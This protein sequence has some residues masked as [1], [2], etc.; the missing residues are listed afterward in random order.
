MPELVLRPVVVDGEADVVFAD[1]FFNS[2][3]SFRRRVS[4]NDDGNP[5]ALAVFEFAADVRVVIFVEIDGSGGVGF[6]ACGGVVGQGV[7]FLFR[8]GGKV[9]LDVFEIDGG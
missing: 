2:R 6:D 9:V 4:G 8:I 7:G 1:E 3:Q 5:R